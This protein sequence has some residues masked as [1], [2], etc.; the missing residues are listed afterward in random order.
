MLY[1][2]KKTITVTADGTYDFTIEDALTGRFL[3]LKLRYGTFVTGT[4]QITITRGSVNHIIYSATDP[5]ETQFMRI[6]KQAAD[7]AGSAIA[8][9]YGEFCLNNDVIRIQISGGVEG[10]TLCIELLFDIREQR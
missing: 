10:Q 4:V 9:E 7:T 1:K 5:T 6:K 2:L 8:G 3:G